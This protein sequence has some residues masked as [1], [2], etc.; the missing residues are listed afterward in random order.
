MSHQYPEFV[1]VQATS[2]GGI[3]LDDEGNPV[4]FQLP[5]GMTV[6]KLS[7]VTP[8]VCNVLSSETSNFFT[9]VLLG[10][11]HLILELIEYM[12]TRSLE[13]I[14]E[15]G[16]PRLIEDLITLFKGKD[17][18]TVE[19][20]EDRMKNSGEID[21]GLLDYI[22]GFDQSY[23]YTPKRMRMVN[24]LYSR[25]SEEYFSQGVQGTWD[26]K[27]N[28]L[29]VPGQPDL[30]REIVGRKH[31]KRFSEISTKEIMGFLYERGVRG[32]FFVDFACSNYIDVHAEL[33]HPTTQRKITRDLRRR[34]YHG[35]NR[36]KNS[37]KKRKTVKKRKTL[38][39]RRYR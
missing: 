7:A 33:I 10:N 24:K 38:K 31:H 32:V 20:V 39:R 36:K 26:Y 6:T 29:N 14:V 9:R 25:S 21:P 17:I 34:G 11:K 12:Q 2:H 3:E 19:E 28:V 37:I 4:E 8:G 18:H 16:T 23:S 35:G 27:I 30:I 13:D 1:I 5:P 22:H 15:L